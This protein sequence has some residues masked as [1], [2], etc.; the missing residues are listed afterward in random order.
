MVS[1]EFQT[2]PEI[3]VLIDVLHAERFV[4]VSGLRD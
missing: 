3:Q 2:L 4:L 1:L